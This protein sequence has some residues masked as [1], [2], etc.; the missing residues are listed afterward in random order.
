MNRMH[1]S[2]REIE[3]D[4]V[5]VAI[6]EAAPARAQVVE[7]HVSRCAPCRDE[8]R[9]YRAVEGLVG[10][11]RRAP[12]PAADPTLARAQLESRLADLKSRLVSFGIFSSPLG[13]ILIGR[14]ERGVSMVEYL[15]SEA[16]TSSRLARLAGADAVE[17]EGAA[18]SLFRD[19]LDYLGGRRTRFDWSLDLRWA[20]SDF[21]R[22]VLEATSRLPYGAVTSYAHIARD[23]GAPTATRAV[24]QALR[25]N[26][27][28]IA[29]PCHRVIGSSGGLTGYAG[30]KVTLKQQLL[31]LEGV[32]VAG[33]GAGH[34]E[35]RAMYVRY[36]AETEYCVP[37]C[38][39]L[40][41]T[42]LS[43]LTLFGSRERAEAVGLAPC[44][45]CRPDL[46]PISA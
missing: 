11:L 15:P 5:A 25:W 23:I 8:L 34:V 28:P 35:R 32:P 39:A 7:A 40:A 4:L 29:I 6:G 18:D 26:P 13:P 16:A 20:R 33:G 30:S 43:E 2:C 46:H 12:V 45:S 44:T 22:R 9:Q 36:L 37:T 19:V 42:P 10:D 17:N 1:P 41:S 31:A 3:P 27:I 14:S 21:Q 38:G 24:A